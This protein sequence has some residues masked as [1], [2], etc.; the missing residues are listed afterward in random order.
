MKSVLVTVTRGIIDSVSFFDN[1]QL[2]V[3]ALSE[4]VKEMNVDH[5]D[6]AVYDSEGMIANAKHFLDER[7]EFRENPELM[8]DLATED[9]RPVYIIANPQHYLGFMVTSPDDPLGYFD[10][11][12]ALSVLGQIRQDHGMHLKF[13]RAAP[14]KGPLVNKETLIEHNNDCEVKGFDYSLIEEYLS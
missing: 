1:S 7:D 13:Y 6:A 2:S 10:P 14:V 4:H 3:L 11:A 9:D 12:E 8:A 5:E